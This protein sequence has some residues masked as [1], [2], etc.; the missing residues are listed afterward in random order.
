MSVVV[1]VLSPHLSVLFL[2]TPNTRNELA[3]PVIG[4]IVLVRVLC[5]FLFIAHSDFLKK[6]DPQQNTLDF[7][8]VKNRKI[9]C[10]ENQQ[11]W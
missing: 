3:R 5:C 1:V 10:E 6:K 11:I 4:T 8:I 9:C 2:K 7:R